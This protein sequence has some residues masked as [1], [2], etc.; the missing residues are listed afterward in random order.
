MSEETHTNNNPEAAWLFFTE[1]WYKGQRFNLTIR[2]GTEDNHIP[3]ILGKMIAIYD[4]ASTLGFSL[5]GHKN[6]K[7]QEVQT[8]NPGEEASTTIPVTSTPTQLEVK[9]PITYAPAKWEEKAWSALGVVEDSPTT[10]EVPKSD[11]RIRPTSIHTNKGSKDAP[12]S[13]QERGI[14]HI[15][16]LK[17]SGDE[18]KPKVELYTSNEK[19]KHPVLL[20]ISSVVDSFL[21]HDIPEED[22]PDMSWLYTCGKIY[23][24]DWSVA[25]VRSDKTSSAGRAYLDISGIISHKAK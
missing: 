3:D 23:N 21:T 16:K 19:L 9:I 10:N 1:L 6:G 4:S 20:A 11:T 8:P 13:D 17:I 25:W 7:S 18:N 14:L 15:T 24:V 12:K 2:E 5:P 22:K